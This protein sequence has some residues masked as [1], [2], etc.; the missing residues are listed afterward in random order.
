MEIFPEAFEHFRKLLQFNTSNPPGNERDAILYIAEVFHKGG[1]L[2]IVAESSNK[3]CNLIMRPA[4][5][6]SA[7]GVLISS[8]C[9]VVNAEA[10]KWKCPPFSATVAEDC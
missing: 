8:H 6:G 9:D 2:P 5:D 7:R 4:G 3:R 1:L 10:E